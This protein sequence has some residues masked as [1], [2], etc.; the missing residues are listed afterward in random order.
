MLTDMALGLK[1]AREAV[2]GTA[3]RFSA[4]AAD[5]KTAVTVIG[6]IAGLALVLGVIAL[7]MTAKARK[8]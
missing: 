5:T 4:A 1:E 6:V 8:A 2:E 3:A 7:I